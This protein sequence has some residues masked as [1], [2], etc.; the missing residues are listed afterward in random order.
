MTLMNYYMLCLIKINDVFSNKN[1]V[2][3]GLCLIFLKISLISGFI[4][5]HVHSHYL[6]LHLNCCNIMSDFA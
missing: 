2:K 4:K 5:R 3:R 6:F 1:L